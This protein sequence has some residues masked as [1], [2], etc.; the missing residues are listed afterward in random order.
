MAGTQRILKQRPQR[1]AAYWFAHL[2]LAQPALLNNPGPPAQ[3]ALPPV[4]WVLP[5]PSVIKNNKMPTDRP[6]GQSDG[7]NC[8]AGIPSDNSGL[9]KLTA[10]ATWKISI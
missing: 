3:V 6:M 7:G 1:N 5:Y 2:V 4:D 9:V 8:P 10:E